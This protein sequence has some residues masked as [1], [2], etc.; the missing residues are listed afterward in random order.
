MNLKKGHEFGKSSL[1]KQIINIKKLKNFKKFCELR[2]KI[3]I[4]RNKEHEK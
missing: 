3:K 2:K 1:K 4:E